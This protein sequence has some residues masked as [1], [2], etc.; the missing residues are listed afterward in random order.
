MTTSLSAQKLS[1][2]MR[3]T[4]RV[5]RGWGTVLVRPLS[6]ISPLSIA[7]P[8]STAAQGVVVLVQHCGLPLFAW[9]LQ[10]QKQLEQQRLAVLPCPVVQL[11]LV[12]FSV[13]FLSSCRAMVVYEPRV[14][15]KAKAAEAAVVERMPWKSLQSEIQ[16]LLVEKGGVKRSKTAALK[17][18]VKTHKKTQRLTGSDKFAI[19]DY[20]G[21]GYC[22]LNNA[23]RSGS[24]TKEESSRIQAVCKALTKRT[25][26]AYKGMAHRGCS[27]LPQ[28]LQDGLLAGATFSDPAF[29]SASSK[30]DQC[31]AKDNGCFLFNIQSK[32]AVD[33]SQLSKYKDEA[34]VLFR[35]N[36][37]F[38][39]V[40]VDRGVTTDRASDVTV[41]T[42]EEIM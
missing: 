28:H 39:I 34:E 35:P 36:T 30:V 10:Y 20:T 33:V 6:A 12:D 37:L 40:S 17:L 7:S 42:M 25:M 8:E 9:G 38:R 19:H 13:P 11:T 32:S 1:S 18:L 26:R 31:Y 41:V 16:Q 2:A 29:L 22:P 5:P 27:G 15:P 4:R 21:P 14:V 23:L 24:P 3:S